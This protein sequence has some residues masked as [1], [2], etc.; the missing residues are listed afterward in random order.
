MTS[1]PLPTDRVI[2]GSGE[3]EPLAVPKPIAAK[4]HFIRLQ[5]HR[6]ALR[7]AL[8]GVRC[9]EVDRLRSE[10]KRP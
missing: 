7:A 2:S 8:R 4:C 9:M 6:I 3:G 5:P 1:E 10:L